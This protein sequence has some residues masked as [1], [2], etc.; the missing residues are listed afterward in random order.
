MLDHSA[1]P[2]FYVL[3]NGSEAHRVEKTTAGF[4]VRSLAGHEAVF[5][6]MV[7]E[8]CTQS[9]RSYIITTTL[10]D[11]SSGFRFSAATVMDFTT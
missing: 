5:D 11:V 6:R 10:A 1:P 3:K 8:A 7:D 2:I 9:G 4:I